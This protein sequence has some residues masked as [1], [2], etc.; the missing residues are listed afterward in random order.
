VSEEEEK[1]ESVTHFFFLP[2][3]IFHLALNHTYNFSL[4][5]TFF[6]FIFLYLALT[7][8]L[9]HKP[10]PSQI[11]STLDILHRIRNFKVWMTIF[12]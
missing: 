7:T 8:L 5:S 12:G 6:M 9:R 1:P 10:R 3:P 11:T 2:Q 4:I